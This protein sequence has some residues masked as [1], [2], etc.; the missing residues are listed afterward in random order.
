MVRT[1]GLTLI[2]LAVCDT[3]RSFRFYEQ[4]FGMEAYFREDGRIRPDSCADARM[5]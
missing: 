5:P 2:A 3:E 4:V 1:Y